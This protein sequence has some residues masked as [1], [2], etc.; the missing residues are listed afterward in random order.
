MKKNLLLFVLVIAIVAC[1]KPVKGPNGVTYKSAVQY[2]DYIVGRQST[3]IKNVLKFGEVA[4]TSLDSAGLMLD[5]FIKDTDKMI[6]E[7]KGMPAWKGDTTLRNAAVRSFSFYKRVFEKD[8]RRIL[9]L[10]KDETAGEEA[11]TEINNI[12]DNISKEE[13]QYDKTFH[14]AQRDFATKNKM[15]LVENELQKK[16][17]DSN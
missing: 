7:I 16:I 10:R 12:V 11:I 13:E 6:D 9:E 15:K 17:D 2:N 5:G 8:Y 1:N 3:L 4:Q 14:N